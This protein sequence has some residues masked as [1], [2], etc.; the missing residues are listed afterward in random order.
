MLRGSPQEKSDQDLRH[1]HLALATSQSS[2]RPSVEQ[3]P[4][5]PS[6]E[7]NGG[8]CATPQMQQDRNE[9]IRAF[10]ARLRGQA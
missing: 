2:N 9:P 1:T 10:A 6:G 5:C 7:C 4:C 3:D 8:E